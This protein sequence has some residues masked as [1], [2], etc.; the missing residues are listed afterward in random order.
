[1]PNRLKRRKAIQQLGM[2]V[3]GSWLLPGFLSRCSPAD[4]GPEVN[5][6][7][8]VAII[9]AGPA[10]LYVADILRSK[11]IKVTVYEAGS[12]VGGRVKSLRNQPTEVY[13]NI[14][15]MSS[16]FPLELG[17][18]SFIGTD[19]TLGK[20]VQVYGLK[21][22]EFPPS[23]N[24]FVMD[25]VAKSAADWGSDPDFASAIAFRQNLSS[26]AGS[27][28][29]VQQAVVAAGIGSRAHSFLNGM[30]GNTYGAD[31]DLAGA[32]GIGEE[33]A[34]RTGDGKIL[35]LTGNP[36]QDLLI[37]RFIG[38]QSSIKLNTPI[39]SVQYGADPI[40][41]TASDGATYQADK[42]IVTVP[43]SVL[44][45]GGLAFSPGLPGT[46][47]SSLAKIGMGAS[48][49]AI[50][51]FKRNFWG[52]TTG[53]I[54]GSGDVPEF[55]SF[56]LSRSTFNATLQITVNGTKALTY[57]S[58]GDNA[59]NQILAD[60]DLLYGGQGTQFVRRKFDPMTSAETDPIWIKEDWT[61][62]EHIFGGYSYPLPGATNEDR[63]NI[64]Q[65][66]SG[67]LFFAG[68][69][70]DITGN[71]GMINGALAS[72]ERCAEEVV[73]SITEPA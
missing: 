53:F 69:A 56:G 26:L 18:D 64:G 33:E 35:V 73:K 60:L 5:Y 15:L 61:T 54:L 39:T 68:E 24:H 41:L 59:I 36:L 3:A 25:G 23:A 46:H 10:G 66:I 70:S 62:R 30:I 55:M 1:M 58:L 57:S 42:V 48:F 16:D 2:G 9:G 31:N 14:P 13:P 72:A 45:G 29:S 7:G 38:V 8:T 43:V 49:R 12:Q 47:T 22:T 27:A 63:K 4:P 37:S 44:K 28:Q 32:G 51:E 17:A 34:L 71:A 6:S 52:E 50:V 67:K 21:T 20:I 40:V 19:S 65:P 11:G